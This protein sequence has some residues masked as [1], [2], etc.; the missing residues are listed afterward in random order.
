MGSGWTLLR[1]LEVDEEDSKDILL[2]VLRIYY[3]VAIYVTV[4]NLKLL[5][6]SAYTTKNIAILRLGISSVKQLLC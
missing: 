1:M 3:I 5:I 6:G 4:V 2:Y